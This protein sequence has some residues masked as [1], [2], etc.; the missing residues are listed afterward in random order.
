MTETEYLERLTTL[1][2]QHNASSA[3]LFGSRA[4]G[5]ALPRSDFDVAVTGVADMDALLQEIDD[6][7]SLFSADVVNLDR[8]CDPMLLEDIRNY[9]IPI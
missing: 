1:I 4:K 3:V 7:P 9:G 2:H 8:P 5:T 6:I